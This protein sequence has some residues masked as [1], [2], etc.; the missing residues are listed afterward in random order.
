MVDPK[1]NECVPLRDENR[2]H[3]EGDAKTEAETEV[4]KSCKCQLRS[5]RS[6]QKLDASG[7]ASPPQLPETA[8]PEHLRFRLPAPGAVR[9]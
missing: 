5:T 7:E 6:L 2:A 8:R 9:E 3:R 1:P 4:M